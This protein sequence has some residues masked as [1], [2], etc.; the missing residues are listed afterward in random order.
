MAGVLPSERP[1]LTH[2]QVLSSSLIDRMASG[3]VVANV[4]PSFV[5][6]DMRWVQ[7]RLTPVQQRYS[8]AWKVQDSLELFLIVISRKID[9]NVRM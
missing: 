4:Q 7:Q 1:V 8:Y 9:G 3:G 5:P 6:T 2:C